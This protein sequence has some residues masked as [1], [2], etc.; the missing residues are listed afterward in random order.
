MSGLGK[1]LSVGGIGVLAV[2]CCAGLPLLLAAA[3]SAAALA[4][5][6]GL[7]VGLVALGVA[8]ALLVVRA[9]RRSSALPS[10][11]TRRS[12]T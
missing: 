2:V 1:S 11:T 4:W 6:G 10:T 12:S 5:A 7:T 3:L 8:V 9:R